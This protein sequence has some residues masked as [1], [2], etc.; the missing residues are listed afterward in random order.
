MTGTDPIPVNKSFLNVSSRHKCY[1]AT[2]MKELAPYEQPLIFM[3]QKGGGGWPYFHNDTSFQL[4]ECW[5]NFSTFHC[6]LHSWWSG[7]GTSQRIYY[8]W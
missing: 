2:E 1:Q 3:F 6:Q 4:I 8:T 7:T 5:R